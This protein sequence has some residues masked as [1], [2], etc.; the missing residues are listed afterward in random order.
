MDF[1]K[2]K[3]KKPALEEVYS[4]FNDGVLIDMCNTVF[5]YVNFRDF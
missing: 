3:E 5:Y 1:Y 2:K 4:Q